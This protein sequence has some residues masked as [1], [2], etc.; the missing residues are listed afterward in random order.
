M[1][2]F[3]N[4][5]PS[6][7]QT[8]TINDVRPIKVIVF[9][10]GLSGILA[11]ILLPRAIEKLE[12]VIYE[13]N[14]AIGGTWLENV[15]PG[16][17]CDIPSHSYQFSFENNPGWS[18]YYAPGPEI[19]A[20]LM[21]TTEKYDGY[22][23]MKFQHKVHK[24]VWDDEEGKWHVNVLD[25]VTGN[26]FTDTAD[27]VISATGLLNQWRYPDIPGLQSFKGKLVHSAGY[28]TSYDH[29]GKRVALIGG[30]SSGIQILPTIQPTVEKVD[31]YMRSQTWI[32]PVGFGAEGLAEQNGS[33]FTPPDY[34]E[35]FKNDPAAYLDF[36]R[37]IEDVMNM[38]SEALYQNTDAMKLAMEA[39]RDHMKTKLAKKPEIIE[40]LVPDF[41]VGCRRL[42]PGPGYLEALGEE[43]VNFIPTPI[44]EVV[45]DG[46]ITEDGKRREVDMIICATGFQEVH[47]VHFPVI[48]KNGINLQDIWD[49]FPE[50]YL[51]IAPAHIPNY[52][53][54]LGPNGGAAQGS[55]VIFLEN[56][57]RYVIKI[58]QKIQREY[59]KSI[60]PKTEMV[61]A[62]RKYADRFF[63]PTVF[64]DSCRMWPGSSL[65]G[66]AAIGNPRWEDFEYELR[67]ELKGNPLSWFG[68]GF[69]KEQITPGAFTTPYLDPDVAYVPVE[70]PLLPK[71][72]PKE[73]QPEKEEKQP[74]MKVGEK[75]LPIR[76][77]VTTS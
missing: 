3:D 11:S 49:D 77:V 10:A 17:A 42:T 71:E 47:K 43:N 52:Y 32:P 45:E 67:P 62:F 57:V 53:C 64:S 76:D 25:I 69:T 7:L 12:L 68:N 31:Y 51:S 15:Y 37:R 75:E 28:D 74:A 5:N 41:A 38:P 36:R 9:G 24:A 13:K 54:L 34:L 20:Y 65:H 8:R 18:S 55:N 2:F 33:V 58:V 48:G 39:T 56:G 23:Y 16:V 19:Q 50:A 70:N 27:V 6:D 22:R 66:S 1:G 46:L 29:R 73:I 61:K 30:G 26:P 21:R 59:I 63:Q 72:G 60:T 35:K 4:M 40:A 14:A 44:Q